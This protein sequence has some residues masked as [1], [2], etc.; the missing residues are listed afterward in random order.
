MFATLSFSSALFVFQACYGTPKDAGLDIVFS[1]VVKSS[2]TSQPIEGIKVS[3]G[4]HS[5]YTYSDASGRFNLYTE[6]DSEYLLKFE[7]I[8][9]TKNGSYAPK[10]T[11]LKQVTKSVNIEI[12]LD[13]K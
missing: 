5:Q 9:S 8:D 6:T 3:V 11:L 10:D 1:G 13:L 12:A 2:K 7:D 4:N